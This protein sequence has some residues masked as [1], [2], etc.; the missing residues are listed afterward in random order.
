[1]FRIFPA[2]YVYIGVVVLLVWAGW[3]TVLQGDFQHAFTYTMNYHH[4]HG[5]PLAH[6]W[7]LAVE[8]QFY[9]MW[10]ALFLLVGPGRAMRVAAAVLLLAPFI[11]LGTWQFFESV[12]P[13]YGQEFE[14]VADALAS[15]C[16]L[17]GIYNSLGS[18]ERYQHFLRSGWFWAAPMLLGLLQLLDK[19]RLSLFAGQTLMNLCILLIIDRMV[20]YPQTPAGKLLNLAPLRF[21]GVLSYSLYLWQQ[22]FLNRHSTSWV[23]AFPVNLIF[24]FGAALAS[25][26][27]VERPFLRL[28]EKLSAVKTGRSAASG[29][30]LIASA[31][32]KLG[33]IPGGRMQPSKSHQ[34]SD[35]AVLGLEQEPP[36]PV[37]EDR[38]RRPV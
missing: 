27:I 33:G 34:E 26:Y 11:R 36:V 23:T 32:D 31:I 2:F 28:K 19:P 30:Q 38:R 9:L 14:A 17:A 35:A 18:W 8:E 12:H 7:S 15:G 10:P 37:A 24:A 4:P 5:W 16:L 20:R 22:L 21:V 1:V 25:Y 13:Y 3:A 6:L 29:L